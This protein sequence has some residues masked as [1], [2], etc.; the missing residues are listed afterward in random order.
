MDLRPV[1]DREMD[2]IKAAVSGA[3]TRSDIKSTVED[4]RRVLH[5]ELDEAINPE[6]TP[7]SS[8]VRVGK[9]RST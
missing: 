4:A 7:A 6:Y 3:P 1:I 2:R 8:P 9:W 5:K